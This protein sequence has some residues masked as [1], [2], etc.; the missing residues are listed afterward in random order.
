MTTRVGQTV[1]HYKILELIGSG[2]MGILYK[3]QDLRLDRFVV[4]KFLPPELLRN[5]DARRRFAQE[6]RAA[7]SIDHPNICTIHDVDE[8]FHG[9][10]YFVMD[11][12]EGETVKQK[13]ASGPLDVH[14]AIDFA[15]QTALGL[16]AAHKHRITHRDIKPAN[17]I[18]TEE[19]VVKVLD[20]GIAKLKDLTDLTKDGVLPGTVAYMSPEQARSE[21]V[22][23]R[24]DIWSLGIVFYEMLTGH[25]P[26]ESEFEQALVYSIQNLDPQPPSVHR[27]ELSPLT[28]HI[29]LTSLAK[30]PGRRYQSAD[31]MVSDLELAKSG[32]QFPP[33][34]EKRRA[35]RRRLDR[36]KVGWFQ[37][38][39][40]P[41]SARLIASI[42]V[43]VAIIAVILATGV[44][45]RFFADAGAQRW[46]VAILWFENQTD[47][48]EVS[49][50]ARNIQDNLLP[51]E[52]TAIKYLEVQNPFLA[53]G[54][55]E[56]PG[57]LS[58]AGDRRSMYGN[59]KEAGTDYV[60]EGRIYE[61]ESDFT[62]QVNLMS[63][64]SGTLD[65]TGKA[66]FDDGGGLQAATSQAVR[67]IE[68]YFDLEVIN[69][70]ED[71]DLD[72]W[73]PTRIRNIAAKKA[74]REAAIVVY[75]GESGARP[76]HLDAIR[77]D[78]TFVA[79]HVWLITGLVGSGSMDEAEAH[80]A[81]LRAVEHEATA[82]EKAMIEYADRLVHGNRREQLRALDKALLHAPGN[83]IVL[84]NRGWNRF[85]LED[86]EGAA[87]DL[88]PV[89]ESEMDFPPVY[90]WYARALV[91]LQ[92][93]EEA[94]EVLNQ[95]LDLTPVD[96]D[97]YS[98]LAAFA[99]R[100]GD[101]VAASRYELEAYESFR[102]SGIEW[103]DIYY[104]IGCL[105][106]DMNRPKIASR[107]LLRAISL[108]FHSAPLH[109]EHARALC[110]MGDTTAALEA[111]NEAL[112]N[113][114]DN[115]DA[116]L[117]LGKIFDARGDTAEAV[118]HYR[119]HL[120]G[121]SVSAS[122]MQAERRLALLGGTGD[123][124]RQSD[125]D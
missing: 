57:D 24:T 105:L 27:S 74:F 112:L 98:L 34:T 11:F 111:V 90:P 8:T 2:G 46:K 80:V 25:R 55:R 15:L 60:V 19:G 108:A 119:I 123:G 124:S 5:T 118:S 10:S 70:N 114:P 113:E 71:K 101:S 48:P 35:R 93:R 69:P 13:I 7:S 39:I 51:A 81:A 40:S 103:Q 22:D 14:D 89:V 117:L 76:L 68:Y 78:S 83:R 42:A 4:L 88:R 33:D 1:S 64:R 85:E 97:T 26:F 115:A 16:S 21:H 92:R 37:R 107:Y 36:E 94:R 102:S 82:F 73:M 121:D 67:Q 52:L 96:G 122:A 72:P 6:A 3:A 45:E 62:L 99:I 77:L 61:E 31:E 91:K 44:G 106:L 17:M 53:L 95:A 59:L 9:H 30:E 54:M 87:E 86:Y 65:F 109:T 23:H 120:A 41:T 84:V 29:A 49:E 125:S 28:D 56:E 75:T 32:E 18:V 100:D 43:V 47:Q 58:L 38:A 104:D 79:P 12:Y 116:H 63:I 50:W 20:F 66:R 110:Q